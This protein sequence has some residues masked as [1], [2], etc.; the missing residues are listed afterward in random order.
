ML[1]AQIV[2]LGFWLMVVQP[3]TCPITWEIQIEEYQNEQICRA[4]AGAYNNTHAGYHFFCQ[5]NNH[6]EVSNGTA[7]FTG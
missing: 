1:V 5:Q 7:T 2:G 6:H 3:T 4:Q